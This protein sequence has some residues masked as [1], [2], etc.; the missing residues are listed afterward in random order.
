MLPRSVERMPEGNKGCLIHKSA[1]FVL[2]HMNK[3]IHRS[4][5]V[6]HGRWNLPSAET[7]RPI[8]F[9]L[10]RISGFKHISSY[11]FNGCQY[12]FNRVVSVTVI[13]LRNTLIV[14]CIFLLAFCIFVCFLSQV[15]FEKFMIL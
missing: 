5:S 6:L 12:L 2:Q 14:S 11:I 1:C 8:S 4:I 3:V 7:R 10:S 9:F 15:I 13:V